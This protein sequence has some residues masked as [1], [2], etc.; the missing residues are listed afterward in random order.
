MEI[1]RIAN[2][3]ER[4]RQRTLYRGVA[5]PGTNLVNVVRAEVSSKMEMHTNERVLNH[6]CHKVKELRKRG[7]CR[8]SDS[9]N[10][11]KEML[12]QTRTT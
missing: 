12:K 10:Y 7:M 9:A 4:K 8:T 6:V 3:R 5:V 11:A 1:N 2:R